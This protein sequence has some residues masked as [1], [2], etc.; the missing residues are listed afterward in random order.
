MGHRSGKV[1]YLGRAANFTERASGL[2]GWAALPAALALV[3]LLVALLGMYWDIS[4]HIDVG[5]DPEGQTY[6]RRQSF[7]LDQFQTGAGGFPLTLGPS[8]LDVASASGRVDEARW[9]LRWT[10]S[11]EPFGYGGGSR[12]GRADIMV[13]QPTLRVSGTFAI[14]DRELAVRS[15]PG[16]QLHAWGNRHAEASARVHCNAFAAP[17]DYA[18]ILDCLDRNLIGLGADLQSKLL[19]CLHCFPINDR[20]TPAII[21]RDRTD[22]KGRG[23]DFGTGVLSRIYLCSGLP[24]DRPKGVATARVHGEG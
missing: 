11:G 1:P 18:A 14:G 9:D 4:L 13:S 21:E 15:W 24:A 12:L 6:A 10:P 3:S 2:P 20:E 7:A 8:S 5:R 22:E 17:E 16:Y 23:L 19:A